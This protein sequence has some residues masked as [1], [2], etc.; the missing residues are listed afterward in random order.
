RLDPNRPD[1]SRRLGRLYLRT[2]EPRRALANL[3]AAA[4]APSFVADATL[5]LDLA[6]AQ[7]ALG[8]SEQAWSAIGRALELDADTPG[9]QSTLGELLLARGEWLRAADAFERVLRSDPTQVS[10]RVHA[11]RAYFELG[12]P[13]LSARHLESLNQV[14]RDGAA[15]SLLLGRAYTALG[16]HE[17][18][19]ERLEHSAR[20]E[21]NAEVDLTRAQSL[22][23][24]GRLPEAEELLRDALTRKPD[25]AVSARE[26][27]A[28]LTV[29]GKHREAA[30][31]F[32]RATSLRPQDP[33]VRAE[34][35]R[36]YARLERTEEAAAAFAHAIRLGE[37]SP[38]LQFEL[39][40]QLHTLERFFE[41]CEAYRAARK[42]G[43]EDRR[44]YQQLGA[45]CVAL[46][47][48]E[49]AADAYEAA[50]RLDPNNVQLRF[51]LAVCHH[52]QG[53]G[54]LAMTQYRAIRPLD[55]GVAER[56]FKIV[57]G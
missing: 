47:R 39:G 56:L 34:L 33:A 2:G 35:G 6:R 7:Q 19:L 27:A 3:Q 23:A 46:A 22:R 29:S 17:R 38:Q 57:N 37:S 42:G 16:Q 31:A 12:R 32:E 49:E 48:Y 45:A 15:E 8:A 4:P 20:L 40:V 14:T 5:Q 44:C 24:L 18:A 10:A 25:D 28:L 54:D 13:N 53:R 36:A 30:D 55:N 52:Q 50:V 43:L 41:A 21:P 1:A 51:A 26:L 9:L 11:A